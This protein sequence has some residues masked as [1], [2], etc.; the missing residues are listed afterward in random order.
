MKKQIFNLEKCNVIMF[1]DT[2]CYLLIDN[3]KLEKNEYLVQIEISSELS[4]DLLIASK[5]MP[6]V[7][8]KNIFKLEQ[9][10]N[11][12]SITVDEFNPGDMV[13]IL[14][15]KI[16][17]FVANPINTE[18]ISVILPTRNRL[19][20]FKKVV[21]DFQKQINPKFEFIAIDDGS[22]LDIYQEKKTFI[23]NLDDFR[24]RLFKNDQNLGI[25][26]TLNR[27]LDLSSGK[28]ITWISDDNIYYDN[29]LS[30]LYDP[31]YDFVYSYWINN[32]NNNKKVIRFKYIDA[33]HLIKFFMG[34]PAVMWQR[35]FMDKIGYF[36]ET[37]NGCED[38]EYLI[39]TFKNTS[40]IGFKKI[41]TME[42]VHHP[43]A[44][45]HQQYAMC[46]T[47]KKQITKK[48]IDQ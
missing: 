10:I 33:K 20:G 15:L 43:N 16:Y 1:P 2:T 24:F 34:V 36:N 19:D 8:G 25:P 37:L 45:F 32:S 23:E 6:L 31:N 3:L 48:Y 22:S 4:V 42:Y 21:L 30:V 14:C 39:R 28:F 35:S 17:Q 18:L 46:M 44:M 13:D 9:D 27:G 26:K 12:I 7:N 47:L 41:V 5:Q 38:Y 29:Y 11:N 40:N